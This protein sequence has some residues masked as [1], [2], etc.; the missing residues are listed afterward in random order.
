[1]KV[2]PDFEWA[3]SHEQPFPHSWIPRLFP[4]TSNDRILEWLEQDVPWNF[5]KRK[6]YRQ[7]EFSLKDVSPPAGLDFLLADNTLAAMVAWLTETFDSPR[8]E[9]DGVVAHLL[10]RGHG[11]GLH[12][13]YGK[14][15]ETLR[16]VLQLSRNVTGGVTALFRNQNRDSVC[17]LFR[18]VH[19]TGIAFPISEVSYH[20]VSKVRDGQRFSLVY[21]F[22]QCR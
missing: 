15:G 10:E 17:R 4:S 22:R 16:L 7:F 2:V 11:I 19:G 21:S 6:F 3:R 20:A 5:T 8:I 13:D 1:M 9:P 12:N 18:P 14:D